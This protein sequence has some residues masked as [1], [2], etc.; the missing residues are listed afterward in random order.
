MKTDNPAP[1]SATT[2]KRKFDLAQGVLS[3]ETTDIYFR[4]A[5]EILDKEGL[6]PIATM[7]FFPAQAGILCGIQETLELLEEV[8]PSESR[9]VYALEEGDPIESREVVLRVRG[10]YA[11]Y[12]LYET[13]LLG[14]LSHCTG[15]AT[16][17]RECVEAAEGTPIISYGAR[18]VHPLVS[19]RMEYSAIVGGCVGCASIDG[20]QLA[21]LPPSGTI[22]HALILIM[23]DTVKA[24]AAF[25]EHMASEVPRIVLVDTLKDEAEEALRVA[26]ALGDRL[27]GV[28]LDTPLE[29]G[30]V[31]ADL[32]KEV[33]ARLDL[34][35]FDH[36]KIV[37]SGGL[38]PERIR[39]FKEHDAPV[40]S[41]GVG[42]YISD[43]RP[44]D[45]TCDIH[46]IEGKPV[47]KRGR[48]PGLTPNPRLKRVL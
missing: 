17:A 32:V 6:N 18:H 44:I 25:D 40:N 4:R 38:N 36:V 14:I 48:I 31:T 12:G 22:P 47:A 9:E 26:R 29:R 35:G 39:Y 45:F 43:T 27:E 2:L 37:V 7:E 10:P 24:A 46:E 21:G 8:L 1:R 23:G 3:G 13:P 19:G 30:G 42:S 34:E 28:R 20:A 11:C 16:A 33:R 5:K 41:F 15:W